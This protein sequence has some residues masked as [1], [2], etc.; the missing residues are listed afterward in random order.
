MDN[1]SLVVHDME[2][3]NEVS[4]VNRLHLAQNNLETCHDRK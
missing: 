3:L 2:N 1:Y 4:H